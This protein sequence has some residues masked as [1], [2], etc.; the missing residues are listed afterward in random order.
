MQ[1]Y[2]LRWQKAASGEVAYAILGNVQQPTSTLNRML[3]QSAIAFACLQKLPPNLSQAHW[4]YLCQE[5]WLSL[6]EARLRQGNSDIFFLA[7]LT[8]CATYFPTCMHERWPT[9]TTGCFVVYNL[10]IYNHALC[11]LEHWAAA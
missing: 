10:L 4:Q 7:C 9:S 6:I 11:I 5:M 1:L 8:V 3:L 2:L